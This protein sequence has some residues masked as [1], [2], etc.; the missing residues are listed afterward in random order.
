MTD[1]AF[2]DTNVWVYAVDADEPAR[3]ARARVVLEPSASADIVVSTQVLGEFYVTVTRKLARPVPPDAASAMV[4]RMRQ[5][6]VVTLDA[7]HVASAIAGSQAWG[8]SYW[9]ALIVVAATSAGCGRL[10]S[11]DLADGTTYGSV[12]V[13]NPFTGPRRISETRPGLD[14]DR[15]PWD[16]A[17][18]AAELSR[19][20][21]A[22]RDAGMRPNAIH[23]YWDYAQR[24]LDW[25]K[26][27][28]RPRGVV[29]HGRPVPATPVTAGDLEQ[30]AAT[31]ARA[32]EAAGRAQAT[33]DTY[34]RHAMFFIRWLRAEFRPG[35]RLG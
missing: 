21:D 32:V 9:D 2:V 11:E 6:P 35:N 25:R 31:Y 24:F 10:L 4:E 8:I 23:A 28:Y 27:D 34:H 13:E 3:Q 16:D 33:I 12:R 18:L 30:E 29:G 26:G 22:C 19:Y 7:D 15:G 1:R 5:L 14:R 20:E 17:A